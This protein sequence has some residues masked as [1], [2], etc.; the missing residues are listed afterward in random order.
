MTVI[1]AGGDIIVGVII[2]IVFVVVSIVKAAAEKKRQAKKGGDRGTRGEWQ[3][4]ADEIHDFLQEISQQAAG[5]RA[6]ARPAQRPVRPA[7]EPSGSPLIILEPDEMRRPAVAKK[8]PVRTRRKKKVAP[9]KAS[10]AAPAA[11]AER[12]VED[13]RSR[14]RRARARV[15]ER[16][17][18]IDRL[19]KAPLKRAILLGDILGTPVARRKSGEGG[20]G[21]GRGGLSSGGPRP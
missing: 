16:V 9:P 18:W 7:A 13:P 19:P 17:G 14:E 11:E 4:P 15:G 20:A 6:P 5:R 1:R 2:A 10:P 3:A 21:P 8:R 12:M